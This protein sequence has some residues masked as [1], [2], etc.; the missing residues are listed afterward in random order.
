MEL[1]NT[2]T[3]LSFSHCTITDNGH[4]FGYAHDIQSAAPAN[5][6]CSYARYNVDHHLTCFTCCQYT[7]FLLRNIC[8]LGR[9]SIDN[10]HASLTGW[11]RRL[12]I[13]VSIIVQAQYQA[14]KSIPIV[15]IYLSR[16]L[17][18]TGFWEYPDS[19]VRRPA[20]ILQD[21]FVRIHRM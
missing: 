7:W 2:A 5:R 9:R 14:P 4:I 6:D 13:E 8:W 12:S 11:R 16:F 15:K 3:R 19:V 21:I 1:L 20:F 10:R 17:S 18:Q